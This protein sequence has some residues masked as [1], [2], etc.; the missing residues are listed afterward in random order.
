MPTT[1]FFIL[2]KKIQS[3]FVKSLLKSWITNVRERVIKLFWNTAAIMLWEKRLL[4]WSL[5]QRLAAWRRERKSC[6]EGERKEQDAWRWLLGAFV[7]YVRSS[8]PYKRLSYFVHNFVRTSLFFFKLTLLFIVSPTKQIKKKRVKWQHWLQF[9]SSLCLA[10]VPL[11]FS[12]FKYERAVHLL[13][14]IQQPPII[15]NKITYLAQK[16]V[17]PFHFQSH[18]SCLKKVKGYTRTYIYWGNLIVNFSLLKINIYHFFILI[19][20]YN[21]PSTIILEYYYYFQILFYSYSL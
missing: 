7:A 2:K 8:T 19:L 11:S 21:F 10:F 14:I 13:I 12:L 5:L 1:A 17:R 16:S 18:V 6:D 4:Q 20:S 3:Y 15:Y 9:L